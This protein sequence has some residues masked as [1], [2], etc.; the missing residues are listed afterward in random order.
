MPMKHKLIILALCA[1]ALL[2]LCVPALAADTGYTG[3]VDP[4]TG[5]PEGETGQQDAG[6]RTALSATMYYD[7]NTHDFAFP[8]PDTLGEVHSNAADGMVL[9]TPVYLT[10]SGD[11]PVEVYRNGAAYTGD[12]GRIDAVGTY[13]VSA[14]VGTQSRRLLSFTLVGSSTNALHSFLAPDGFF[15]REAARDGNPI[16]ADRFSLSMET[17]GSYAVEY[18]CSAT[19]IVYKLET[20]IDRT[21]PALQFEGSADRQGRIR[22]ALKFS[23]LQN[24]DGIYLTRFGEQVQP[25]FNGD[26]TGEVHDPGNYTMTV[27]DSAGNT[28]DYQF[29][30]L[31]YY[32]LQSWVFFLLV[33]AVLAAV[34]AY[35]IVKRRRLKVA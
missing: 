7:W 8:I 5:N 25:I 29:I 33:A 32:N 21:P 10:L 27:F 24:G 19:D 20:T 13:S 1:V 11:V 35:I 14:S 28:V 9:T 12:R 6:S 18:E 30:I 22:S 4:E 26:G 23:G 31:Q 15:V 34:V 17:E 2:A 3:P 16:Y